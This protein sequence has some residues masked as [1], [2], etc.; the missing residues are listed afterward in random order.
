LNIKANVGWVIGVFNVIDG[1][2]GVSKDDGV[3]EMVIG[4]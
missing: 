1:A 2:E 3:L 4:N